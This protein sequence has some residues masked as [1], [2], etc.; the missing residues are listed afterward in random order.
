MIRVRVDNNNSHE[1]WDTIYA[2]PESARKWTQ[3]GAEDLVAK[4]AAAIPINATVLDVGTG[5]GIGPERIASKRPDISWWGTDRSIA[6][7]RYLRKH[8]PVDWKGLLQAD[9]VEGV[10]LPHHFADVVL[11]TELLEHLEEPEEGLVELRR[12]ARSR[13][14]I[15]VPRENVVDSEYHVWSFTLRD[16]QR[17]LGQY[18]FVTT[19]LARSNRQIVGVCNLVG[20]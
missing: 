4:V 20:D 5:A 17:M 3:W 18:G 12:L 2:T 15:T 13:I 14:I 6:A 1:S 9:I 11:C 16:V 8:S 19:D 7:I 10:P